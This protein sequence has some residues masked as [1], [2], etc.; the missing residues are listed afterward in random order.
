M[1]GGRQGRG[2]G[3]NKMEKGKILF[4]VVTPEHTILREGNVDFVVVRRVEPSVELGSEIGIFPLHAPMLLRLPIAPVRYSKEGKTYYLVVAGGFL[5]VKDERVTI[6]SPAAEKVVTPDLRIAKIAEERAKKW[7]EEMAGKE[8]FD[9][10]AAEA[11]LKRA[12]VELYKS[13]KPA[14]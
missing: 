1:R 2:E 5:E 13:G 3:Q 6:L 7:L 10:R 12:M 11:E 4:E 14:E 9:A 8:E